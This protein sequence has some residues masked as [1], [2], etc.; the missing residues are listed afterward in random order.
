MSSG[1]GGGS[2]D[3]FVTPNVFDVG[4]CA[5]SVQASDAKTDLGWTLLAGATAVALTR[6]RRRRY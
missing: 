1:S 2:G 3:G 6:R 4:G 5:C